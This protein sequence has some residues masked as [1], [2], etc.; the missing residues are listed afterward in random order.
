MNVLV[1]ILYQKEVRLCQQG[2]E[3]LRRSTELCYRIVHA[4]Q[5]QLHAT[6]K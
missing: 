3:F 2:E 6:P 4:I 1:W 5:L